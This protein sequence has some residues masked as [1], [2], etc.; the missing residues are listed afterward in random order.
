M[1]GVPCGDG[2]TR[3]GPSTSKYLVEVSGWIDDW[4]EGI[5]KVGGKRER[6]DSLA[7]VMDFADALGVGVKVSTDVK[8][9]SVPPPRRLPE[10][11]KKEHK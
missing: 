8:H 10:L 1:R 5:L 6:V 4:V 2:S 7:L 3:L 9:D 11:A